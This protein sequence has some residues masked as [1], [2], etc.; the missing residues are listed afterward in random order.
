M[1]RCALIKDGIVINII[2]AEITYTP[3]KDIE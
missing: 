1:A 3:P 2:M